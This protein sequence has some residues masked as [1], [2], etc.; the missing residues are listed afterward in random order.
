[1]VTLHWIAGSY[2]RREKE[3]A[4]ARFE[5]IQAETNRLRQQVINLKKQAEAAEQALAEERQ[6]TEVWSLLLNFISWLWCYYYSNDH[7]VNW[8]GSRGRLWVYVLAPS[9]WDHIMAC[10]TANTTTLFLLT[11]CLCLTDQKRLY[12]FQRY[13]WGCWSS[14][15]WIR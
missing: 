7:F 3:L 8:P 13:L 10:F 11:P 5:V 14:F 6:K 2:L 1:M 15:L 4:E 9:L 12:G